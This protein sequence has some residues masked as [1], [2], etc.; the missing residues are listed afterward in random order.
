MRAAA[1]HPAAAVNPMID[2]KLPVR[3]VSPLDGRGRS[4]GDSA[5]VEGERFGA[6]QIEDRRRGGE[7]LS[8][9]RLLFTEMIQRFADFPRR[10][11]LNAPK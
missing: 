8:G 9:N 2:G 3:I 1:G 11:R 5:N 4:A 10:G 7:L 6:D